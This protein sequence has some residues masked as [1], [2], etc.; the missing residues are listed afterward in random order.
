MAVLEDSGRLLAKKM[1][2][3]KKQAAQDKLDQKTTEALGKMG[4]GRYVVTGKKGEIS[5]AAVATW[6]VPASTD[7]PSVA[8]AIA[9]D[10]PLQSPL[11]IGDKLV[12]NML[13]ESNYLDVMKHFQK[14]IMPGDDSFEGVGTSLVNIGDGE[15]TGIAVTGWAVARTS[16]SCPGVSHSPAARRR[17]GPSSA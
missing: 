14:D 15:A 12:V 13:E 16:P 17:V 3:K 6:V 10:H 8:V 5:T 11:Q 1:L 2:E 4:S 7:P 9:K